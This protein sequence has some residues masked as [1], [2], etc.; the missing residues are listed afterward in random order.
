MFA[1]N[2]YNESWLYHDS[3]IE[4]DDNRLQIPGGVM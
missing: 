3:N 1:L 4:L 2:I